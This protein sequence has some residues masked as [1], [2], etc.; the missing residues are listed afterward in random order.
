M[1]N[2][3]LAYLRV[4]SVG[5]E[6]NS[7]L[8]C[9]KQ[10][11]LNYCKYNN[12]TL[13]PLH[14]F[15]DIESGTKSERTAFN[16]M[17]EIIKNSKSIKH[18][19]VYA[20]DRLT[21]SV[22]VGEV[23]AQEVKAKKGSIVSVSQGFDD[24]T[25]T[26]KMTRQFLTVVAEQ[27]RDTIMM[28]TSNGRKATAK[29]GLFGGGKAP[30]GYKTIGQGKLQIDENEKI[31]V[32]DIFKLYDCH[33]SYRTIAKQLTTKGYFTRKGTPFNPG[34]IKKIVDNRDFYEGKSCLTQNLEETIVSQHPI[35]LEDS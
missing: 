26:G 34:S 7:S 9:Q 2:L 19:V 12:L 35:I 16:Q 30:L 4:S 5:Q 21:R 33:F 31:I 15:T 10:S 28:R 6:N 13:D 23:I 22:Y 3:V 25:P 17:R 18:V 20:I 27:E 14:I 29:K 24:A 32:R 11:I 8:E 1:E